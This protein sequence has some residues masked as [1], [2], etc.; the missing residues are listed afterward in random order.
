MLYDFELKF[1]LSSPQEDPKNFVDAIYEHVTAD[2]LPGIGHK[3]SIVLLCTEEAD[4]ALDAIQLTLDQL[5]QVLPD[6]QLV[7]VGPDTVGLT[8]IADQVG[9]SRQY[10]HTLMKMPGAPLPQMSGNKS[11][12]R[13]WHLH[14]V[15]E[16]FSES[17]KLDF[18]QNLL[19]V[20][21]A[22]RRFNLSI[23]IQKLPENM[24]D[25]ALAL[26]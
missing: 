21:L 10:I 23:G 22:A 20:S 16:W 11:S 12:T 2:I 24:R 3:G 5:K 25:Q 4:T 8:G 1:K 18:E 15:L 14:E 17:D 19:E 6:A 13:F 26:I 7:E 9:K